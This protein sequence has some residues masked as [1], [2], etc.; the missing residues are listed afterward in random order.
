MTA[1]AKKTETLTLVESQSASSLRVDRDKGI[2]YGVKV[3]GNKSK[4]GR[5]YPQPVVNRDIRNYEGAKV[6]IDHPVEVNG[7]PIM[8][9]RSVKSRFGK[10]QNTRTIE[11]QA[12]GYADL[13]YLKSHP[14][15]E[16]IC[17]A[18]ESME[19]AFAL[20]H[21]ADCQS[22]TVNGVVVVE[23]IA[24]VRS[25]DIVADAATNS[26][27]YEGMQMSGPT[28]PGA[29]SGEP[30]GEAVD[31]ATD[32]AAAIKK[33][34]RDAIIAILGDDDADVADLMTKIKAIL[35]SQEDALS[36]I[37][38]T[39]DPATD[40]NGNPIT[41]AP[42]TPAAKPEAKKTEE[43]APA[44]KPAPTTETLLE[45]VRQLK[46]RDESRTLLESAGVKAS[47]PLLE[48][49]V[50][51]PTKEKRQALIDTLPKA[52]APAR[53]A[54]RSAAPQTVTESAGG[55]NGKPTAPKF[56]DNEERM[57]FLRK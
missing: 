8:G 41:P 6:N 11:G 56:K 32:P 48:A 44:A 42:A 52:A 22:K 43:S 20:S 51:L 19:D 38:Q 1:T 4:R 36:A 35:Q 14:L 40:E 17:E 13:K 12:G 53:F 5:E 28:L 45:E 25:V 55:G 23:A 30:S 29:I 3:L 24:N 2:I 16:L 18:A 49:L 46:A 26:T 54:P 21:V 15:A 50:A 47:E 37:N 9:T 39:P 10:L 33:G 7:K 34:F 27:L 57:A 31:P